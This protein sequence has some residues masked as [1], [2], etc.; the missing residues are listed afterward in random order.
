MTQPTEAN[1]PQQSDRISRVIDLRI[2]LPW[3]ITGLVSVC[4][5]LVSMW[6]NT[7]Q[8]LKD[9]ADIQITM[10]AGNSQ[11]TTL[12]GE[13]ALLRFRIENIENR[14]RISNPTGK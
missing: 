5:T 11:T 8:L 10:K 3:L 13:I 6:F 7:T 12:A 4:F 2:P 9:V 14:S 1:N